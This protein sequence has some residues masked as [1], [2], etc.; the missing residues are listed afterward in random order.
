MVEKYADQISIWPGYSC[1]EGWHDIINDAIDEMFAI[2]PDLSL[3]QVKEKFGGLRIYYT[4]SVDW[5]SEQAATLREI[6]RRA[7][8]KANDTCENC[9][10][11]ENVDFANSS[12]IRRLCETCRN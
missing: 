5:D 7:E 1:G 11:A 8:S 12:W 3:D 2:D 9:G 10:S 6:V 4:P